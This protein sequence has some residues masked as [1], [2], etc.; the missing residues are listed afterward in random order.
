[1]TL[2]GTE[3]SPVRGQRLSLLSTPLSALC[4]IYV[5]VSFSLYPRD[6]P[7]ISAAGFYLTGKIS[8]YGPLASD[9]R[10]LV[11]PS[12]RLVQDRRVP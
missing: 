12:H 6:R 4:S 2:R 3:V 8:P 10:S 7:W 1:M 5:C 9:T 11:V